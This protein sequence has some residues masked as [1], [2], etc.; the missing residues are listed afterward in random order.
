MSTSDV[1]TASRYKKPVGA[2]I[3]PAKRVKAEKFDIGSEDY[4]RCAWDDNKKKITGLINRASATNVSVIVKELFKCNLIRYRGLFAS[5]LLRAQE[6]S[7]KFTDVYA[8][9]LAVINSRIS[10][11]GKLVVNRLILQY[12]IAFNSNNKPKLLVVSRFI[13]HLTNQDVVH[14]LLGF[15]IIEHLISQPTPTLIEI[16]TI[17]LRE[18]GAKLE[19]S[20]A[21]QVLLFEVFKKLRDISLE[22]DID[23]RTQELVDQ[24]HM[25][26][27]DKFRKYP[28][29]IDGLD[30]VDEDDKVTH[31]I[32]L[33]G[34]EA[35]KKE[36][37]QMEY[38]YF[39]FEP[40]W[41]VNEA[42]YDEFRKTLLEGSSEESSDE[43]SSGDEDS[44]ETRDNDDEPKDIKPVIKD[45][46]KPDIK[47]MI[48][49]DK[50]G[51]DLIAFRRT[52][53]L[54]I[55]SSVKYE[56]V[57]HKLLK[58]GINSELYDEL[59]QMILDCCVQERTYS[60]LYG[61]IASRLCQINSRD[62]SPIFERL[63][64]AFYEIIHKI[65]KP[66]QL[67]NMARFY[68]HLLSTDSIDWNCLSC[69]QLRENAT[70]APGR[71]FIKELFTELIGTL[72]M[73]RMIDYTRDPDK[74]E[75]F[76]N[77]FPKDPEQDIVFAINF[78]KASG[79]DQMTKDLREELAS[80]HEQ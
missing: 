19:Q 1:R 9:I 26:R 69:L 63:L 43:D 51:H 59:C 54:I 58:S 34:D 35:P 60:K 67:R 80:K 13:A 77:L 16:L 65:D 11:I 71:I 14:E 70:N 48:A 12:R 40:N 49:V 41:S 46:I 10:S 50:T 78:F 8:A 44:S 4:Q 73:A 39:K 53:F 18:C 37:F 32:T 28:M 31:E 2:Y 72:T 47:P 57:V 20:H 61:S 23:S 75:G 25:I 64:A 24:I 6:T 27:K 52:V 62:F 33:D 30:I 5:A 36:D 38:N 21:G 66:N 79:L 22:N 3:P 68:A 55:R 56:E 15:Q 74:S 76:K 29:I 45:E 42:K 17:F 7:P